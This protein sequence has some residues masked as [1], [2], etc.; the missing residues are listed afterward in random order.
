MGE[1]RE[2]KHQANP[3]AFPCPGA[4]AERRA[5]GY[6]GGN[7]RED[8]GMG[9]RPVAEKRGIGRVKRR[10]EHIDVGE[11]RADAC[12]EANPPRGDPLL[13]PGSDRESNGE[14]RDGCRHGQR[15]GRA[16]F[17]VLIASQRRSGSSV[18]TRSRR[19]S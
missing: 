3:K 17:N 15:G 9:D 19:P 5:R 13:G 12:G 2:G 18:P 7:E 11:C 14:M 8:Q 4:G 10:R 16:P 1:Q 6:H